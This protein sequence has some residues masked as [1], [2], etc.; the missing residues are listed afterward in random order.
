VR[1]TSPRNHQDRPNNDRDAHTKRRQDTEE[2]EETRR[3]DME[4]HRSDTKEGKR[5]GANPQADSISNRDAHRGYKMRREHTGRLV[6]PAT[7]RRT[8]KAKRRGKRV[9]RKTWKI[10]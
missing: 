8:S 10:A 3:E 2:R 6:Q 4:T 7:E 5:D 1:G 9:K